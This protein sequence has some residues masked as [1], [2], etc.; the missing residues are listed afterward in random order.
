MREHASKSLVL[1]H[2]TFHGALKTYVFKRQ[3]F[4]S[5]GQILVSIPD[6]VEALAFD[7]K[8]KRSKYVHH[9]LSRWQTFRD[10]LLLHACHIRLA[11]PTK[12]ANAKELMDRDLWPPRN[13]REL[14]EI[15]CSLHF[16]VALSVRYSTRL[17]PKD[18]ERRLS[19][20]RQLSRALL[21][22]SLRGE[23][24]VLVCAC[25]EDADR[26]QAWREVH[27]H[28]GTF[29][30]SD[31]SVVARAS[32]RLRKAMTPFKDM[33]SVPAYELLAAGVE[34][35]PKFWWR[36]IIQAVASLLESHILSVEGT[37][38]TF[39]AASAAASSGTLRHTR[40][41]AIEDALI[42]HQS[43]SDKMT[44]AKYYF[45]MR[46]AFTGLR[47]VHMATDASR[48]AQRK[49]QITVFGKSSCP[50]GLLAIAPPQG[51][52][53]PSNALVYCCKSL[54]PKTLLTFGL[55]PPINRTHE[56]VR[57]EVQTEKQYGLR[58]Q[59]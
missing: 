7:D 39:D 55:N 43:S 4:P 29:L 59:M 24:H 30:V 14:P 22:I 57:K 41:A 6:I 8:A 28:D 37:R 44:L 16:L 1:H 35:E 32:D 38:C 36:C 31:L 9:E 11:Q 53:Q 3:Q 49:C 18:D 52:L 13:W 23:G 47:V 56:L 33:R 19:A 27:F 15:S 48:I 54:K 26:L 5:G 2:D 40:Q 12:Q 58:A 10:R 25:E 21:L 50:E 45:A 20:W 46:E 34:L 42:A 17:Y 51:G